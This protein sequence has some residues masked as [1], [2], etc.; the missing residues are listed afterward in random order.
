[1]KT[2]FRGTR[3]VGIA[4]K[5]L[6]VVGLLAIAAAA[7]AG[8]G[9]HAIQVYSFHVE[10]LRRAAERAIAGEQVNGLI[11]A[12]VMDS[13]GIYMSRDVT[14]AEKF[15]KPL[16][17]NLAA[18][19]ARM[20]Y[21]VERLPPAEAGSLDAAKGQVAD[22]VALRTEMV[23]AERERGPKAADTIGNNDANRAN[24]QALNTSIAALA[25]LNSQVVGRL[26]AALAL[27]RVDM[28]FWLT[29]L[30]AGGIL[31]AV[32]LA[33][34]VVVGGVTRPLVRITA[35]MHGLAAGAVDVAVTGHGRGDEVGRLA[36]ALEV[37][38]A[39]AVENRRLAREQIE[40]STQAAEERR[41]ALMGL[42]DAVETEIKTALADIHRRTDGVAAAAEE[43]TASARRTGSAALSVEGAASHSL[44]NAQT[45][46]GAAEELAASIREIGSRVA[47]SA[48]MAGQAVCA[49]RDTSA[50]IDALNQTVGRIGAV[51]ELISGIAAQTNLLALNATIE[52]ARA[53]D[54]GKGF[55]VVASEVKQLAAQT[56]RCTGEIARHIADVRTATAN[57]VGA[58]RRIEHTIE[59]IDAVAASIATAVEQ[60]GAATAEIARNVAG[61]AEVATGMSARIRE[62]TAEA[63]QTGGQ[64]SRV[65]ADAGRLADQV[66]DL[67]QIVVRIV[68]SSTGDVERRHFRCVSADI[69]VEVRLNGEQPRPVRIAD[70]SEAGAR[71]LGATGAAPGMSG[72]L[73]PGWMG[74]K[75]PLSF[76]VMRGDLDGFGIR[77]QANDA[78]R[79]ALRALA[80][81][82]ASRQAA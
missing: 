76:T 70:L 67:G 80:E 34:I 63:E 52:A 48:A 64:A 23:R 49:G 75:E 22:F 28:L 68:R 29:V 14:E 5:I 61:I 42:A 19:E 32:A 66:R 20:A 9:I 62:V 56:A 40:R 60:Q 53:G 69:P 16:L 82:L 65:H 45:V 10:E 78:V 18:I 26:V 24:R 74:W 8:A 44:D 51:A 57:S 33:A 31:G 17:V 58:V 81:K 39:Q 59:E 27:F 47:C 30:S 50:S 36:N 38:R 13:R 43:M 55:A 72:I 77:F 37:F 41:A 15:A 35:A 46:A 54:A 4:A 1:M 11:N 7:I 2:I 12:V 21:W 6:A 73:L 25:T 71:L 3:S 79:D